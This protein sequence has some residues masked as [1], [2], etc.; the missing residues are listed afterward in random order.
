MGLG[1]PALLPGG[2]TRLGL[3]SGSFVS[4]S[5]ACW[6]ATLL[7]PVGLAGRTPG[8]RTHLLRSTGQ[9]LVRKLTWGCH[10]SREL[11]PAP[12]PPSSPGLQHTLHRPLNPTA[13]EGPLGQREPSQRPAFPPLPQVTGQHSWVR[14]PPCYSWTRNTFEVSTRVVLCTAQ[15]LG[16]GQRAPKLLG[17]PIDG[18]RSPVSG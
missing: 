1:H 13:R 7:P 18:V 11:G 6:Q 15:S 16:Q 5:L 12:A 4:C 8:L 2:W 17:D 10:H 9:A 3:S 14:P